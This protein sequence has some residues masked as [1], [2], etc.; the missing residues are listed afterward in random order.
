M[1]REKAGILDTQADRRAHEI[2]ETYVNVKLTGDFALTIRIIF[3]KDCLARRLTLYSLNFSSQQEN[4]L[5]Q[6]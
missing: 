5:S 4:N 3:G 2:V 1:L 6:G